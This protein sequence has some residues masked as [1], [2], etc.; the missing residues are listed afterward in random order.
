MYEYEVMVG[1]F[2][3]KKKY[4]FGF[5]LIFFLELGLSKLVEKD[6]KD[7]GDYSNLSYFQYFI[8]VY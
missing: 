1:F 8:M 7:S 6:V 2:Q 5:L 3:K 4:F